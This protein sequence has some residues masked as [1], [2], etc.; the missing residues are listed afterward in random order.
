MSRHLM[1]SSSGGSSSVL[2]WLP[3]QRASPG[4]ARLNTPDPG[5]R[6]CRQTTD[7]RESR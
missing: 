1:L 2:G 5:K 6:V 4:G 7:E 3:A